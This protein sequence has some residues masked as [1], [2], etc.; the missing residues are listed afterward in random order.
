MKPIVSFSAVSSEYRNNLLIPKKNNGYKRN[1]TAFVD[2]L[3][4]IQSTR[5]EI[6]LSIKGHATI[7]MSVITYFIPIFL[8]KMCL[9]YSLY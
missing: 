2:N 4:T 8:L 7:K 9:F 6:P 5:I 3:L 1:T